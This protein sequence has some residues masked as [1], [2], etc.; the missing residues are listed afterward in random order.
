MAGSGGE[1]AHDAAA[2]AAH[3]AAAP[4]GKAGRAEGRPAWHQD[5]AARAALLEPGQVPPHCHTALLP[6]LPSFCIRFM[7]LACPGRC[8]SPLPPHR[9]QESHGEELNESSNI[10]VASQRVFG[11]HARG[12]QHC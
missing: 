4:H 7:V 8:M 2:A 3:C 12:R 11:N 10:R 9:M 1:G 5:P 6:P